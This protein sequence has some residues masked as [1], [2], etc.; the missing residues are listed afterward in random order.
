MALIL[1]TG[2]SGRLGRCLV[3]A[4]LARGDKV[5]AVARPGRA[6]NASP[7]AGAQGASESSASN[8]S[9]R[10]AGGPSASL[11]PEVERFE[12][13]LSSGPLPSQAFD[14]AH[15]AVHLA[16]L[17]GEHPY[18]QLVAQNAFATKNFLENCP[19]S[20]E[21]IALA[22]SISVYG[23]YRGQLVDETFVPKSESPYGKSKLLAETFAREYCGSLPLVFLRFGMIYGPIFEEG[24]F[25]VLDLISRGKMQILGSGQ[26][27]LP[28]LHQSD[29]VSAILLSLQKE[30][31]PCR[32]YN[33]VGSEQMAQKELFLL[34]AKELGAP[35]PAKNVPVAIA[36]LAV[37]AQSSL[38]SI[39]L[40]KKPKFS[41]ENIRQLTLDRAYSCERAR[42]EL[43][44]EARVKIADGLKEVVKIYLAKRQSK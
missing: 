36:S 14:G 13:D 23:E 9:A 7:D 27:R 11:P 38:S 12:W 33:I 19:S 35:A 3:R 44:F 17:V 25:E 16:G 42:R 40:A 6:S 30:T 15:F 1:V 2:A 32:E 31:P 18:S 37:I 28:L 26:N 22:S 5:R 21:K 8:A 24:Y 4:L 39:G 20:L 34:A 29:A 43:G 10:M 41:P